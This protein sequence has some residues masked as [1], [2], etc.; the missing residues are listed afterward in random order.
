MDPQQ[1]AR[2]LNY[3]QAMSTIRPVSIVGMGQ[4]EVEVL[5][6]QTENN[7]SIAMASLAVAMLQFLY[8]FSN[9]HFLL[10]PGL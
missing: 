6:A 5:A 1:L 4:V 9:S 3:D 2:I 7:Q 8:Y 10:L